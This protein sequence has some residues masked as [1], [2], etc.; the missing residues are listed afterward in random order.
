[1]VERKK[2]LERLPD[3]AQFE[4]GAAGTGAYTASVHLSKPGSLLFT[5]LLAATI[6]A[7]VGLIGETAMSKEALAE[8]ERRQAAESH[9]KLA[10]SRGWLPDESTS[11]RRFL[12]RTSLT[13]L[14]SATAFELKL[15]EGALQGEPPGDRHSALWSLL[16]QEFARYP[17]GFLE[18]AGLRAVLLCRSLRQAGQ[19]IPSLP[20]VDA[21]LL[22]DVDTTPSFLRRLVHHE[23]FHFVDFAD[24]RVLEVDE[25]WSALNDRFFSYGSGGRFERAPG[26]SLLGSGRPGFFTEY[27]MAA[28]EED[29]AEVFSFM[30]SEPEAARGV[31]RRDAVVGDKWRAIER[32]L[33]AFGE[34]GFLPRLSEPARAAST[35]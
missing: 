8:H 34:S 29:K 5:T 9:Q 30:M 32:Q 12:Q 25:A 33:R 17:E 18:R 6:V 21:T 22:L 13:P 27:A 28:L 4:L 7:L 11:A 19:A 35:P 2:A 31:A 3:G 1:M 20:N 23:V 16:E 14:V 24:D 10:A 15:M 26:A